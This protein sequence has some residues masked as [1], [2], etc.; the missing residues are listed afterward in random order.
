VII[1]SEIAGKI[2][3]ALADNITNEYN[4]KLIGK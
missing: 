3:R 1:D 4:D 2:K